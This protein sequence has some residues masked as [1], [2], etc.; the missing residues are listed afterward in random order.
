MLSYYK[1]IDN[2][3]DEK[4]LKR[5][6]SK[7][8][9][10]FFVLSRRR[11]LKRQGIAL[12]DIIREGLDTLHKLEDERCNSV[13]KTS[14]EFGKMLS[15]LAS[16]GLEGKQRIIAEN[17]GYAVGKWI[18]VIDAIDDA[19][20][21]VEDNSYNPVV[22]LYSGNS[23][24]P[25]QIQSLMLTLNYTKERLMAA[26]DLIDYKKEEEDGF[27]SASVPRE[28]D[29]Y[30]SDE[31]RAVIENIVNIGMAKTEEKIYTSKQE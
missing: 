14:D 8:A 21:D 24:T 18:Y 1:I 15:R 30:F 31:L 26:I 17:A 9:R 23:P 29:A 12:D 3:K 19:E 25:E 22:E 6:A 16:F 7:L 27:E 20:R 28:V 5:F 2:I 13:D 10:P 11:V 4:G